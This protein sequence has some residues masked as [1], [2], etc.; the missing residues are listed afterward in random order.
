MSERAPQ[1][2]PDN[3]SQTD[4]EA[5]LQ[6]RMNEKRLNDWTD[7]DDM[8]SMKD[9]EAYLQGRPSHDVQLDEYSRAELGDPLEQG[10]FQDDVFFDEEK[11]TVYTVEARKGEGDVAVYAISTLYKNGSDQ[12]EIMT[13]AEAK[14][15][16]DGKELIEASAERQEQL[17]K[18]EYSSDIDSSAIA[19][20]IQDAEHANQVA[21]FGNADAAEKRKRLEAVFGKADIS[22]LSDE[23][24]DRYD[25]VAGD[26]DRQ[27]QE[28]MPDQG[29]DGNV[30]ASSPEGAPAGEEEL[31]DMPIL[32]QS[33]KDEARQEIDDADEQNLALD[34]AWK[35]E[36]K[37]ELAASAEQN[38]DVLVENEAKTGIRGWIAGRFSKLSKRWNKN[39][40]SEQDVN[41]LEKESKIIR[42]RM[43]G[44][45]AIA[46]A[47]IGG[48]LLIKNGMDHGWFSGGNGGEEY[49]IPPHSKLPDE[50]V[51]QPGQGETLDMSKFT[52]SNGQGGESYLGNNLGIDPKQWYGIENEIIA[53]FPSDTY[54]MA[55]GH[56]GFSHPGQ[57]SDAAR[58][59]FA[60]LS[61]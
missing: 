24:L 46:G 35:Q 16:L 1:P 8:T 61:R 6:Q 58:E 52:I 37:D 19:S 33:W 20:D 21:N 34:Q 2:T 57:L 9:M 50:V 26:I 32:D 39:K 49:N 38:E 23:D 11:E 15:Y 55:D 7:T 29:E 3:Q 59:Y 41:D 47:V 5:L 43:I 12:K 40:V 53:K 22:G 36:V 13:E 48:A 60:N 4:I 28:K 42:R 44:A 25:A 17:S 27:Y 56:V 30:A 31:D 51:P 54:R 10:L 18:V 14:A 45:V